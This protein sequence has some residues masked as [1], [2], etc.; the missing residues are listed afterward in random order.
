[1]SPMAPSR[2]Q[3]ITCWFSTYPFAGFLDPI[4]ALADAFE[5]RHPGLR[6]EISGVPYQELPARVAEAALAG[7]SPDL[8][9][10]Y[11]GAGP[12][13]LDTRT[14]DGA[15]MFIPIE[16]AIDGRHD[17]LGEPVVEDYLI[18]TRDFYTVCGELVSSPFTLTTKL[19]YS[20]S[21]TLS[22]AGV[23]RLPESRDDLDA[24]CRA[25]VDHRGHT[26]AAVSWPIDG[27]FLQH[28][29][30]QDGAPVTDAD[31]GRTGR[32]STV[33]FDRPEMVD[34]LTWWRDLYA[35]GL[36]WFGGAQEDWEGTFAALIERRVAFRMSSSFDA[37]YMVAAGRQAG[38][39]VQVSP[40]PHGAGRSG[41]WLGGDSFWLAAGR[42]AAVTDA[43]LAFVQ[44]LSNSAN[45]AS[46]HRATGST[47]ATRSAVRLLADEGWFESHPHHQVPADILDLPSTGAGGSAALIGDYDGI[48][49][50][51]MDAT[52]DIV[53]HDHDPAARL[54][55]AN[56]KAQNLL[57]AY[58]RDCA[59]PG[60]RPA[61]CTRVGI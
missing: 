20:D 26:G 14:P 41:S 18:A 17:I 53:V 25:V 40:V 46:W 36:F 35:D 31:N 5:Q 22:A 7:R 37:R 49:R 60:P 13:A 11:S 34:Y 39:D 9:T 1:M 24:A 4:R 45:L 54:T 61:H 58:N 44:F 2:H 42:P 16:R 47:P 55:R 10:Y 48:Q 51:L 19:L 33:L 52:Q 50:V 38:L 59:G 57:D 23:S 27:K 21:E 29:M 56:L 3:T 6:L 12:I 30:A 32:P 43:A 28:A 8:A 15:A